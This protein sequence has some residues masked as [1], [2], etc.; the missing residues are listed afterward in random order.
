MCH[1]HVVV[2]SEWAPSVTYTWSE[3]RTPGLAHSSKA[4][5]P[6]WVD[7]WVNDRDG[8]ITA[9]PFPESFRLPV[10]SVDFEL[11]LVS[12]AIMRVGMV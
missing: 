12:S 7:D 11:E 3:V 4:V 2:Q 6:S 8:G 10:L 5:H 9:S 1:W